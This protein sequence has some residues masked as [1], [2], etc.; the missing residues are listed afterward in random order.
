MFLMPGYN[1]ITIRSDLCGLISCFSVKQM[2]FVK[3]VISEF[4][5]VS[6]FLWDIYRIPEGQNRGHKLV[7]KWN[8]KLLK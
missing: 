8:E 6:V 2:A 3:S 7:N 5:E 1:R 4:S